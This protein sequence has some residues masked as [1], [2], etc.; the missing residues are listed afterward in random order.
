MQTSQ[1][2]AVLA[3]NAEMLC[4]YWD[5]ARLI[6]VRQFMAQWTLA[7]SPLPVAHLLSSTPTGNRT[8]RR[9]G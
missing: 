2:N 8:L 1:T 9:S 4:L 5:I 7:D 6:D 3:A